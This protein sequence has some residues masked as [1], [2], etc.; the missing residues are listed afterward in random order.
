[1]SE[2]K[3][4][5]NTGSKGNTPKKGLNTHNIIHELSHK[6][7]YYNG[8]ITHLSCDAIVN[9]ANGHLWAGVNI[10]LHE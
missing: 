6:V 1:M 10:F 3:V 7:C 8:S 5:N 4:S 2:Q 9:A